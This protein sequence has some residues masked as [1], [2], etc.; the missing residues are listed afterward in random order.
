MFIKKISLSS[1]YY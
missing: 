1:Q